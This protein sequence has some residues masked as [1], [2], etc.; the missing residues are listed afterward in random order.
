MT[1]PLER[2]ALDNAG[3]DV[4]LAISGDGRRAAFTSNRA[5][6]FDV[7]VKHFGTGDETAVTIS[8]TFE[9]R[10]A[11][12]AGTDRGSP[13]TRG[14]AEKRRVHVSSSA[15]L[16]RP[17][18]RECLRGLFV[19]WT[20]CWTTDNSLGLA[21]EPETHRAVGRSVAADGDDPRALFIMWFCVPVS[22]RT[23]AGSCSWPTSRSVARRMFIAPFRGM[24]PIHRASWIDADAH[25][26][27][28]TFRAGRPTATPFTSCRT[29]TGTGADFPSLDPATKRPVGNVTA[30]HPL[31]RCTTVCRGPPARFMEISW[32]RPASSSGMT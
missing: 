2:L 27:A 26:D 28:P 29:W 17:G 15:Y 8:P 20:G 23:D 21:A 25:R 19:L 13:I 18:G 12:S 31:T 3:I 5:G 10:P 1:G 7:Y 22:L 24:S 4:E 14:R 6:N 9:S 11:I 30:V 16:C 32:R